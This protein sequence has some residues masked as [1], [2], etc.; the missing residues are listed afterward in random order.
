[1][2]SLMSPQFF[3]RHSELLNQATAAIQKRGYWSAFAEMPSPKAYGETANSDGKSAFEAHHNRLFD[4]GQPRG[5][6]HAGQEVSPFGIDLGTTYNKSDLKVLF[7]A[8]HEAAEAWRSAGPEVWVGVALES[9]TRLNKRSFEIAYSVMHT[10]GQAFMMA[11]QAGA[12]HA[13]ERALE[14]VA[15]AWAEMSGVPKTA[16][17]EKPQG[18]NEPLKME[19][20][21]RVVPR[22]IALVIGCSTFPTWNSYP[23]LFA[24]LATG[25]AVVVKPHPSAILPLAITVQVI[26]EVLQDAGYDPNV[27]TLVA[28]DADD[29]T[30]QTLSLR[31]DIKV[32]DFTGSSNHGKWIEQNALQAKVYTEKAG[33]NQIIVDSTNDFKGMVRNIA[34][35]LSLYSGQM[36]TAPQNIYIPQDGIDTAE[37]HL[38]FDEV[39][40][41]VGQGIEKLL[42]DTERAVEVLGAIQSEATLGRIE[43]ARAFGD[44]V[45]ES[46]ALI[47][48]LFPNALVRT[49]ILLKVNANAEDTFSREHFGPISFVVATKDTAHSIELSKRLAI[50]H[51]AMTISVYSTDLEVLRKVEDAAADAGIS[52]SCNLTG[53]VFVNQSAAYS[54]FHGTGANPAA[55]TTLS[56]SSFVTGRFYV[57]QSR[58]HL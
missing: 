19:K 35:S 5:V 1:M 41:A 27:A 51:G 7:P 48:P 12:P 32:I 46:K 43:Q 4:L 30:T 56:D 37:G 55:N 33:V 50:E 26:R 16:Y 31:P 36:C 21:Y 22:G 38:S 52:L 24:S 28:H 2:E 34:F 57:S 11:F 42:S 13:Q 49:P 44:V 39:S 3:D 10:T 20:R 14:A 8:I 58:V 45:V 17:W 53:S 6:G 40:S 23:G 25:N 29:D 54:D 15:Y 9:L 18:K 47:H